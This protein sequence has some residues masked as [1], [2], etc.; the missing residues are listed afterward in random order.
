MTQHL[1]LHHEPLSLYQKALCVEV[2]QHGGDATVKSAAPPVSSVLGKRPGNGD[3]KAKG[4]KKVNDANAKGVFIPK[5]EWA[6][7]W[8]AGVCMKCDQKGRRLWIAVVS[9]SMTPWPHNIY[10][11]AARMQPIPSME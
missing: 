3:K 10:R 9:D 7:R 6:A 8:A 1:D 4:V 11:P 5:K 2:N